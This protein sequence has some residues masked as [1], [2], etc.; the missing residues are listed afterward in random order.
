[1]PTRLAFSSRSMAQIGSPVQAASPKFA[2]GRADGR[3]KM[4]KGQVAPARALSVKRFAEF[5]T[6]ICYDVIGEGAAWAGSGVLYQG[7][8]RTSNWC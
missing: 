2:G 6:D 8:V 4:L 5:F 3:H 7:K 1:V